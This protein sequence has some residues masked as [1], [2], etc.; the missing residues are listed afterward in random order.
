MTPVLNPTTPGEHRYNVAHIQTRNIVERTFGML[1]SRSRCL[2]RTGGALLYRP[3]KVAQITV[4]CC[5]LHNIAKCH[6]LEHDALDVEENP[7]RPHVGQ[8][9][10]AGLQTGANLIQSHFS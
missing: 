9:N 3:E 2:D 1:K 5:I 8:L 6:G 4:V 7:H 10:A